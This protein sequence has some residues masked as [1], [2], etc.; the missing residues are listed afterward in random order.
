MRLPVNQSARS[1]DED[2][3]NSTDHLTIVGFKFTIE[4]INVHQAGETEMPKTA[5]KNQGKTGFVKEPL[6]PVRSI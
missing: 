2:R 6:N 1:L 3:V 5:T 4:L